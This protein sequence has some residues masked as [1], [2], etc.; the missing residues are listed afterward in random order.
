MTD[1]AR[2]VRN[3]GAETL[4]LTR[5]RWAI[6]DSPRHS[7]LGRMLEISLIWLMRLIDAAHHYPRSELSMRIVG[8]SPVVA[9][10]L[11]FTEFFRHPGGIAFAHLMRF[12]HFCSEAR[13]RDHSLNCDGGLR[14]F[15]WINIARACVSA[16]M[17]GARL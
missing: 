16:E 11:G 12:K 7:R 8:E 13:H 4:I 3:H 15:Y 5:L 2:G 17:I 10:S 14:L 9:F 6:S 1:R